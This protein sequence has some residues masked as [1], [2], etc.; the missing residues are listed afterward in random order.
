M[1]RLFLSVL[2]MSLTASYV[3]LIVILV[4]LLLKKAPKAISYALWIVVAFRLLI[5]FT[6]ESSFSLIPSKTNVGNISY[7]RISQQ[8]PQPGISPQMNVGGSNSE[9]NTIINN[10][11][12]E[13][14]LG[15]SADPSQIVLEVGAYVWIFV[16]M[17]L[18]IYSFVSILIIK[19]RLK[20]ARL[21]E[22]NIFEAKNIRTAF[23]LGFVNPKIYLPE[24]LTKE[25]H[26]YIILHEQTHIKRKDHIIKVLAFFILALHWFNPLVWIAF[27]L[28]SKDMELSCDEK[29]LK[30]MGSKIKKP[31]ANSLLTLN[32]EKSF[33]NA[34][35]LAFGEGS[36]KARIKNV[37]NYKKPAFW[38]ILI[39]LIFAIVIGVGLLSNPEDKDSN[40]NQSELVG[41]DPVEEEPSNSQEPAEEVIVDNGVYIENFSQMDNYIQD[42]VLESVDG[43][44]MQ[45]YLP[46]Y[47]IQGEYDL[48]GDGQVDKIDALLKADYMD[49][50][51]IE[52]ND[53]KVPLE[54]DSPFGEMHIIDIDTRDSF[55]EIAIFDDG[56]SGDPCFIFYRYDGKDL[57]RLGVIDRGAVMDGQGKFISW[58]HKANYFKPQFF[59]AWGEFKDGRYSITNHDVEQYIGKDYELDGT[60]Y[61][62]PLDNKPDNHHEYVDW[63]PESLREF[64][65]IKIKILDIYVN[66]EDRTLNSF[67]VELP[68][69]ERGLLYFWIGD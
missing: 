61:F 26:D 37:L 29:V 28:M 31:Y 22:K 45:P 56:P 2:D 5:P 16:I 13:P 54:L 18:L 51:Y 39:A 3:I 15:A 49:G 1:S 59:S 60:A 32:T 23:V 19:K 27:R 20:G 36:V 58:F 63:N 42:Y 66:P 7:Q 57:Y 55:Y 48:N 46:S 33:I 64:E 41:Q 4:R 53:I 17:S 47:H 62:L 52:V 21:I 69:G 25:E 44:E 10:L 38:V 24:G 34:S 6:F 68:E 67:Y 50:G 11:L 12:P 40:E 9:V 14:T 8:S 35:P 43:E 30:Q 65:A